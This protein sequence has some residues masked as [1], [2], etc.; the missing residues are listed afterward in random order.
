MEI[1]NP[2]NPATANATNQATGIVCPADVKP[3]YDMIL[4]KKVNFIDDKFPPKLS[5]IGD[6]TKLDTD[7][8][9]S[10]WLRPA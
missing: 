2:T 8:R 9:S 5:T 4:A 7:M 6:N 1:V 10:V 3:L